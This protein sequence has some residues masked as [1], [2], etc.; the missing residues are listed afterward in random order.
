MFAPNWSQ[1]QNQQSHLDM[2]KRIEE[3]MTKNRYKIPVICNAAEVII[4]AYGEIE[5]ADLVVESDVTA[6]QAKGGKEAK[7]S[8]IETIIATARPGDEIPMPEQLK[9]VMPTMRSLN[10]YP[11]GRVTMMPRLFVIIY[12]TNDAKNDSYPTISYYDANAGQ[13]T[14]VDSSN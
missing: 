10:F 9:G 3:V 14:S 13:V 2:N 11:S 5:Y 4:E 8:I 6:T 7:E 12:P 1:N